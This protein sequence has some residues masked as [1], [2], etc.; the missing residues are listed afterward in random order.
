MHAANTQRTAPPAATCCH[1]P[2]PHVR[3]RGLPQRVNE[4]CLGVRLRDLVVEGP[5]L[6]LALVSNYMVDM[7]WLLTACR[8][9][10]KA[11]QVRREGGGG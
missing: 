2:S 1:L 3:H 10:A 6:Q 5:G 9:L 11:R 8:D 7:A 4:G